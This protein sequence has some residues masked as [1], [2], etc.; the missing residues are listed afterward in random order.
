MSSHEAILTFEYDAPSSAHLVAESVAREVGEID[1]E[2]S[3][4]EI[5]RQGTTLTITIEARDVI[6]LRAALNT[7]FSLV[8]VAERTVEIVEPQ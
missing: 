2:R 1:D 5:D 8:D 6:A 4:T 7:W 3:R